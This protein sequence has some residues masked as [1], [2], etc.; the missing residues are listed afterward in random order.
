[1]S[2]AAVGPSNGAPLPRIGAPNPTRKAAPR[3]V[4][5]AV[6]FVVVFSVLGGY[7]FEKAGSKVAVVVVTSQVAAGHTIDRSD[8]S[9]ESVAGV[10]GGWPAADI[11]AVVGRTALMGLVPG[12][13]MLPAMFGTSNALQPGKAQVGML[14]K[15]GGLPADGLVPG[16]TVEVVQL[17]PA[18]PVA[19][20]PTTPQVLVPAAQV[21]SA[22]ADSAGSDSTL[23]TVVVPAASAPTV[24]AAAAAGLVALVKVPS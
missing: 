9:T 23:V 18:S 8:V 22:H 24:A 12:Q 5:L 1:L 7:L 16:D 20:Q 11:N 17:P 2:S 13:V 6:S 3:Y 15:G 21:F 19:G 14:I 10:T 4:W